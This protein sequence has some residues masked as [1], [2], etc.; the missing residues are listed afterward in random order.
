ML[1]FLALDPLWVVSKRCACYSYPYELFGLTLISA[2]T[3][4]PPSFD[5]ASHK[6]HWFLESFSGRE[7]SPHAWQIKSAGPANGH[8]PGKIK[9]VDTYE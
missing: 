5:K 4:R 8:S 2:S 6:H 1:R 3:L 9:Q 7:A